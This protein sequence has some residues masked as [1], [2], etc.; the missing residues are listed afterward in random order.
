M[1][2][3]IIP[4]FAIITTVMAVPSLA[5]RAMNRLAHNGNPNKRCYTSEDPYAVMMDY[6]DRQHGEPSIWQKYVKADLQGNST[7][8]KSKT[9]ADI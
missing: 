2:W 5:T 9:L 8:Y 4:S 3:E 1:W 6:R 7:V